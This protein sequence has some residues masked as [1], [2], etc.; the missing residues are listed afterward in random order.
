VGLWAWGHPAPAAA[1]EAAAWPSARGFLLAVSA[2]LFTFGGWHMGTYAAGETRAAA[3]TI[4]RAMVAAILIVTACYLGLNAAYIRVLPWRQVAD[5]TRVAADAAGVLLGGGGAALV[6]LLVVISA[7]GALNGV[8]LAG[9]RVYL[10]MA[11]DRLAPAGL[12]AIHPR[13]RTPH[14]ALG[15]QAAWSCVLV[16]VVTYRGLFTGV[17]YLE[18]IFF[19]LMAAGLLRHRRQFG[20]APAIFLAGCLLVVGNLAVAGPRAALAILAFVLT[21]I[22]FYY[23]QYRKPAVPDP[24]A[25]DR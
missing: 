20:W 10:A 22:P 6:S 5:S 9:P 14:R 18:W 17:V 7:L 2:G 13:F 8:I 1:P 3:K 25:L 24:Y 16:A 19:G 23:W 12:A 15:L 4:P 21:G 11:R